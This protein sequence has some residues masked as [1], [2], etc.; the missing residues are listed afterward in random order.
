LHG[1]QDVPYT[2]IKVDWLFIFPSNF[3]EILPN[4]DVGNCSLHYNS[5]LCYNCFK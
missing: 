5:I 3:V 1:C 2:D 4:V